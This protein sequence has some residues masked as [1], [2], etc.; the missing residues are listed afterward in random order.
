MKY[1]M[2]TRVWQ[3]PDC[4]KRHAAEIAAL[5]S[6][7]LL[8]TGRQSARNNGSLEDVVNALT[9]HGIR[10][11]VFDQV[12]E[13]PSVETVMTARDAGLAAGADFVIG[14]GGGSPLDA[15]KAIAVMMAHPDKD[16]HYLYEKA[17][18]SALPVIA[19]PTTCG[20]GSEVTGVSV[21]TRHDLGTKVSM[22]HK[23]FPAL[24]L[25]DGKYLLSAPHQLLVNTA[26]DALAHLIESAVN[27]SADAYSDMLAFAGLHGWRAH[28]PYLQGET[29]LN[30][31]AAQHLM[32][33]S[34]LAGMSIA[35]TGTS[36][37][38][39]LSYILTTQGDIPHG[40][41]VGIF[42]ANF[43]QFAE[44]SRR[45]AVLQAAGFADVDAL[46]ETLRGLLHVQPDPALLERSAESVLH[47]P[48]KLKS[49]PYPVDEQTMRQIITDL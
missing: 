38:H 30:A 32:H 27:A 24:A 4:V 21:L 46:R 17:E 25:V 8:V 34:S 20:T 18:P 6:S 16:W 43:L 35:Q 9:T 47:N 37:P 23:V 3:E 7:A 1:Y 39:A 41:A 36:I 10:Y 31:E 12:E 48:A 19:V 15:A 28:L 11:T 42:Q 40:A 2:P 45:D 5:G 26:V 13:N 29:E 33:V 22:T 44:A 49:C 14:I